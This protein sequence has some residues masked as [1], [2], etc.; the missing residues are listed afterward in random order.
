[1]SKIKISVSTQ[2]RIYAFRA[3]AAIVLFIVTYLTMLF[4]ALAMTI[5]IIYGGVKL[6]LIK[7]M[8]GTILVGIG[9]SILGLL[10]LFFLLKFL[11]KSHKN[12]LSQLIEIKEID[13][14]MLFE[15]IQGIV[16]EIG[17]KFPKKIYL[18]ADVNASV[19][20]DSSFWSMF[21]PIEKNLQIGLGM[22]NS[23]TKSEFAAILSHEF[24][25][26]SQKTMKIGSYVYHVNQVIFNLLYD[27]ESYNNLAQNFGNAH[28]FLRYF[29]WIAVKI[30]D[31]MQWILKHIY[32][33]LNISYL[34]LSRE[35]EFQADEIAAHLMGFEPV[36]SSLLRSSFSDQC[37]NYVFAFYGERENLKSSNLFKDHLFILNFLAKENNIPFEN[38]LPQFSEIDALKR[39]T[40]KLVL[41]DQWAS[42][43]SVSERIKRI[44]K[45]GLRS[46]NNDHEAANH[47]F[48]DIEE[49][50]KKVTMIYFQDAELERNY[51]TI[52]SESFEFQ[53]KAQYFEK[54]Y[55]KIFNGY[56]DNKNPI[57]FEINPNEV[58]YPTVL[59]EDIFSDTQLVLIHSSFLLASDIETIK[60]ISRREIDIK[61]FDYDG[62]KYR[63]KNTKILVQRLEDELKSL[64]TTI[65]KNDLNIYYYFKNI[66]VQN[67]QPPKLDYLYQAFFD[68]DSEFDLLYAIYLKSSEAL[69]FIHVTT[70][71][72]QIRSNLRR[73]SRIEKE[74]KQRLSTLINDEDFK[75]FLRSEKTENFESYLSKDWQYF[76]ENEYLTNNLEVVFTAL[77]NYL[78]LISEVYQFKKKELL[79]YKASL[80]NTYILETTENK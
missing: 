53:Y 36:K 6:I 21:L 52:S 76:R 72:E 10:V 35:M 59:L 60:L 37:L 32:K 62:T 80:Y 34:G 18:T 58:Q 79:E 54:I 71:F 31:G 28:G 70:T 57:K 65:K 8:I 26:F 69:N 12:D 40:S 5:I 47:L 45:T 68:F 50:Q 67:N 25:H 33:I 20:Y 19:F 38:S 44:E 77:N 43:P 16:L 22:V 39:N 14:P 30:T 27:N 3:V 55:P 4:L 2:Y 1:M 49:L 63:Y 41:K 75:P 64:E 11:I 78:N 13:E 73:F 15:F 46:K 66:E 56:Y 29:V 23:V 61:T 51:E 74:F 48:H 17:T 9:L 24:G 42:H 7:P